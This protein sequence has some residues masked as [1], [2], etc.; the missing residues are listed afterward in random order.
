MALIKCWECS[1]E[2]SDTAKA[3]PH[4]SSGKAVECHECSKKIS[5]S[6]VSCPSCGAKNLMKKNKLQ[7]LFQ[8]TWFKLTILTLFYVPVSILYFIIRRD[9]Y[10][11]FMYRDLPDFAQRSWYRFGMGLDWWNEKH[12]Q[13]WAEFDLID[14][15]GL[16]D[17]FLELQRIENLYMLDIMILSF[18]Y[19]GYIT[20]T[21]YFI[22]RS[23]KFWERRLI[24]DKAVAIIVMLSMV[25]GLTLITNGAGIQSF[26]IIGS[27]IIIGIFLFVWKKI[28]GIAKKQ[29]AK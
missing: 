18:L 13:G 21:T 5:E 14:F 20:L 29:G 22:N 19:I 28:T 12:T 26:G 10:M 25:V 16:G 6:L 27:L 23:S 24:I 11:Q 4:C 9:L 17:R 7:I 15:Y 3:C 2:I 8:E 1:K